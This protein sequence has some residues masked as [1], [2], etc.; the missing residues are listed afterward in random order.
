MSAIEFNSVEL[1]NF[2]SFYGK[3][4][5][6]LDRTPGLYYVSG[7]NKVAPELGANGVGKSTL[8]DA[9][10][11]VLFGKTSRDSRP[12][13]AVVPWDL[14]KGSC[15]VTLT[16]K[17][18]KRTYVLKRSRRPN[19]LTLTMPKLEQVRTIT[20]EELEDL[21]GMSEEMF[22]RTVILGQFGSLFLDLSPEQQSRMFNG[23][24]TLDV[25]LRASAAAAIELKTDKVELEAL[26]LKL[27]KLGGRQAELTESLRIEKQEA[28]LF[29][30]KK[31]EE[32]KELV[33]KIKAKKDALAQSLLKAQPEAKTEG[34]GGASLERRISSLRNAWKGLGEELAGAR[35]QGKA[36]ENQVQD[37][38]ELLAKYDKALAGDKTCP[39]CG[40]KTPV[41]HLKSKQA[42]LKATIRKMTTEG[43]RLG[44]LRR[45]FIQDSDATL[46][47]LNLLNDVL[48]EVNKFRAEVEALESLQARLAKAP[49]PYLDSVQAIRGR[50][51]QN[52]DSTTEVIKCL[53]KTEKAVDTCIYWVDSFKE[54]RLSL[55]NQILGELELAV[56]RHA[57]GLGLE[58][59]RIEFKTERQT[60]AGTISTAFSILLYPPD[61][62]EPVKFESYS[63]GESQRWQLAVAFGL[64]EVIMERAGISPNIEVYD[65]PTR[66]LSTEGVNSLL[67]HLSSRAQE[68]ER[69]IYVVEHH[70]LERGAFKETILVEMTNEGSRIKEL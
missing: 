30:S 23:A 38:E 55:I 22:R 34:Q 70:S 43:E 49:N 14:E 40:Q 7:K 61:Q 26:K 67:D 44:N 36:L 28:R 52:N 56:T 63:G 11:W 15:S 12:A 65:E 21:I 9:I 19:D 29:D 17:R 50:I 20:Q 4:E 59:W 8:W 27:S 41:D 58:G 48:G 13:N 5:F 32:A 69:C 18:M 68:L 46:D 24:L 16:F 66:G 3:H 39:A 25:W 45:E 62:K 54:I 10:V 31:E 51:S 37:A 42:E 2:K 57:E 53:V 60:Q 33:T 64:S 1:Q 47:K 35:A 6:Q